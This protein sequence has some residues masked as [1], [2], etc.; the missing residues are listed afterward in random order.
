[1]L[2]IR[3]TDPSHDC[4]GIKRRDFLQ[5]GSLG[6]GGVTLAQLLA[7]KSASAAA[8]KPLVKDRAV[9][10]LNL[11]G[12]PTHIE[13]FDPK[14][15]A[16]REYRAM[17]GEVKTRLPGVTFG[18]HFPLL[19][20]LA[21]RMAIVR[22]YSHG[23]GSHATA[24]AHVSSGGNET[25]ATM[26]ALYARVAGLTNPQTGI[27]S[28]TVIQPGAVSESYKN[29][30]AQI[31][32]ITSSGSLPDEYRP[33]DPSAGGQVVDNMSLHVNQR[34]FDDRRRL[35]A[36]LDGLKRRLDRSAKLD[37]ADAFQQQ[38]VDVILGGVN[39]AF[40]FAQEPPE[41][42]DRYDTSH[43]DIP[44]A[45]YAKKNKNLLK[46]SP[47]SLGKQMLMARRLVEAGCGFVTVTSAGWDMHGN[48]FGVDDGMPILGTAVDKAASAFLEDL[49]QRGLDDR[50][51]F[52]MTGEFG[53]TPR[54]NQK[55]GRDHWGKLC[56]LAFSG[57]GLPMGQVI[58]S[59]DRTASVPAST[60]VTSSQVLATILHRLIDVGELRLLPDVPR[61]VARA[62]T[63]SSPIP[64]LA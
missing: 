19:A 56:T 37:A 12:G 11:Q 5:I 34:R 23:I 17:F 31:E 44:D 16:P 21:D 28:N 50:V 29:L 8:G 13:T 20:Q 4:E 58:G 15:S 52:V 63:D 25:G 41:V 18:H 3:S 1:M 46:Q 48:A 40:N 2:T 57:G 42:I 60:P 47:V 54:I 35:L 62:F 36:D 22:S 53:R 61:D 24:A 51:L 14:M 6:I 26:G 27:P 64:Q 10:L 38:A 45:L 55:G 7:L 39:E 59:S 43:I 30:G 33:F 9:V 32:R 49:Q